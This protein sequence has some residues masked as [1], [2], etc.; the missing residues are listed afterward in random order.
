MVIMVGSGDILQNYI[1]T[2]RIA[3]DAL[4][5][6]VVKLLTVLISAL[7]LYHANARIFMH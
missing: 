5:E 6:S 7:N 4:I 3:I 1:S 2:R